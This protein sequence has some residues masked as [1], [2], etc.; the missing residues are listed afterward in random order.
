M[1]RRGGAIACLVGL[2][3]LLPTAA[4]EGNPAG[5][6]LFGIHEPN[7]WLRQDST[8][9]TPSQITSL[10]GGL[11]AE[12]Q[13]WVV[14]WEVAE[15]NPPGSSGHTYNWGSYKDIYDYDL[16]AGI[17]PLIVI[18]DAPHW[19]WA[20]GVPMAASRVPPGPAH[21]DD[22]AAFAA[23]VARRFPAAVGIE[24]WNEPN[25]TEFWGRGWVDPNPGYYTQLLQSAYPAI[26]AQAPGMMVIGGATSRTAPESSGANITTYDFTRR[27]FELGGR[28][29]MDAVSTHPAPSAGQP[30]GWRLFQPG[31]D[32]VRS[33]ERDAGVSVPIWLT[34]V[35]ATT[36]PGKEV[37]VS[38]QQQADVLVDFFFWVQTQPD[39]QA[40]FI[41]T[42]TEP[43]QNVNGSGM[44]FALLHGTRQTG[45]VPKPAYWALAWA[46][47]QGPLQPLRLKLRYRRR[48]PAERGR[49][50]VLARCSR[51]SSITAQPTGKR[52]GIR[53]M[54][55]PATR[56]C[57]DSH[58]MRLT[59]PFKG[60][61]KAGG[62]RIR[63][64]LSAED[65]YET[66]ATAVAK[67]RL[68]RR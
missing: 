2:L 19:A 12:A 20:P 13:R 58:W 17:R 18:K 28:S 46:A 32:Y 14:R 66:R 48:Q 45:F 36:T 40:F 39:I 50:V 15:S 11:H 55:D 34:E 4:A 65:H 9:P 62:R 52:R 54:R 44:G 25:L 67:L 68:V 57:S 7:S 59:F 51:R 16:A 26:K 53:S 23:A 6:K 61:R 42:L 10:L 8:G 22:W 37:Q 30:L 56:D 24:I 49:V 43:D 21:L 64:S 3:M 35:G 29:Y 1:C 47:S 60:S 27:V 33:A 31:I 63:I 5:E 38:E 41:H